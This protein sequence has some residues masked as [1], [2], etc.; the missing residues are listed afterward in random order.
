MLFNYTVQYTYYSETLCENKDKPELHCNGVCQLTKELKS[1]DD[2]QSNS[3][4]SFPENLKIELLPA[5]LLNELIDSPTN[6]LTNS[7][8]ILISFQNLYRYNPATDIFHPPAI[9]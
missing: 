3:D 5:L 7:R 9:A 2:T 1:V 6:Q 4:S 8:T